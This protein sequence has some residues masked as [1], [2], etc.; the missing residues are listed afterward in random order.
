MYSQ[1]MKVLGVAVLSIA[2]YLGVLTVSTTK[3]VFAADQSSKPASQ[4]PQLDPR[5]PG[6]CNWDGDQDKDDWCWS[7]STITTTVPYTS[8][9]AL[10]A[11][12]VYPYGAIIGQADPYQDA[13]YASGYNNRYNNDYFPPRRLFRLNR[14]FTGDGD[15]D[16]DDLPPFRILRGHRILFG[17]NGYMI[18]NN[19]KRVFYMP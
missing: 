15:G 6:W 1:K 2:L 8:G 19:G 11:G 17:R 7:N 13:G 9:S 16:A 3:V 4:N 5:V 10:P 14:N 18:L 12:T